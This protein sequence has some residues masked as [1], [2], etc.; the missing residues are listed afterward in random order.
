MVHYTLNYSGGG[1]SVGIDEEGLEIYADTF[2]EVATSDGL[3]EELAD[4]YIIRDSSGKCNLIA[5]RA[6]TGMSSILCYC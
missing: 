4:T 6:S 2:E 3:I 5:L 1:V